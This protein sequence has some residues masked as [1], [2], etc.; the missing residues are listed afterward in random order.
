MKKRDYEE[1]ARDGLDLVLHSPTTTAGRG[2]CV[3]RAVLSLG[4]SRCDGKWVCGPELRAS[5][6]PGT[7]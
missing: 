7:E 6:V 3:C 2:L 5:L 4:L 1:N